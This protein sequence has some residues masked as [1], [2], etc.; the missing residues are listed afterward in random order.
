MPFSSSGPNI[1]TVSCTS[2]SDTELSVE[3]TEATATRDACDRDGGAEDITTYEVDV[4]QHVQNG[5][6]ISTVFFNE[7]EYPRDVDI[8]QLKTSVT[9]LGKCCYIVF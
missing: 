5:N 6:T 8:S 9:G 3:W 2:T 4:L 1:D 7:M